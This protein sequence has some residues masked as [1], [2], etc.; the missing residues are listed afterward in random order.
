MT[1]LIIIPWLILPVSAVKLE[2]FAFYRNAQRSAHPLC[3]DC[4]KSGVCAYR[5][6]LAKSSVPLKSGTAK[7]VWRPTAAASSPD[8][9]NININSLNLANKASQ[10]FSPHPDI[11]LRYKNCPFHRQMSIGSVLG[12]SLHTSFPFLL[13][14]I[15]FL[16]NVTPFS[17]FLFSFLVLA[18]SRK[19]RTSSLSAT[20]SVLSFWNGART[21]WRIRS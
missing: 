10:S 18:H 17:L 4:E 1:N 8:I 11:K 20:E 21:V 16:S 3:S 9:E 12:S 14:T 7:G 19:M 2:T 15:P 13:R 6:T 5:A